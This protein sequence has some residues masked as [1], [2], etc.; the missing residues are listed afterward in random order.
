[1]AEVAHGE[2]AI[3]AHMEK[4]APESTVGLRNIFLPDTN[5]VVAKP[6]PASTNDVK[7][8]NFTAAQ[9]PLAA[10][11]EKEA[12]EHSANTSRETMLKSSSQNE[13]LEAV[14]AHAAPVTQSQAQSQASSKVAMAAAQ[15]TTHINWVRNYT[16]DENCRSPETQKISVFVYGTLKRGGRNFDKYMSTAKFLD[17]AD[18]ESSPS[19]KVVYASSA[20]VLWSWVLDARSVFVVEGEVFEVDADTLQK[21][22]GLENY[23]QGSKSVYDRQCA[24]VTVYTGPTQRHALVYQ[25]ARGNV[26]ENKYIAGPP[27]MRYR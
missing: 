4:V 17:Q 24:E 21:L 7:P 3:L 12:R 8:E 27:P 1:M 22:D 2:A 6:P 10:E 26:S 14:S 9:D 25:M 18:I 15:D 5:S 23:N 11:I 19:D 13:T 16:G 20:E